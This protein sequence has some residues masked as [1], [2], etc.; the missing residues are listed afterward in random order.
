MV[1]ILHCLG[2][3]II[4][5]KMK[6]RLIPIILLAIGISVIA[7]AQDVIIDSEPP[8]G[9]AEITRCYH[10]QI[11]F[12]TLET[13][14]EKFAKELEPD[15]NLTEDNDK[16]LKW[17]FDSIVRNIARIDME[18]LGIDI[19]QDKM[20]MSS[21][22][23]DFDFDKFISNEKL[24]QIYQIYKDKIPG[25]FT[26]SDR[27]LARAKTKH[28]TCVIKNLATQREEAAK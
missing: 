4:G 21:H 18:L 17:I 13:N 10:L 20:I 27:V 23:L 28:P 9:R 26:Y 15:P 5:V 14:K 6:V 22:E 25:Y 19:S 7:S 11:Y 12:N 1:S 8:V 16:S 3:I 2:T 24:R